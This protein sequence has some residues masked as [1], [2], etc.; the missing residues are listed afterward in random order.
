[1]QGKLPPQGNVNNR[2]IAKAGDP[3]Q[4]PLKEIKGEKIPAGGN[5]LPPETGIGAKSADLGAGP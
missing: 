5:I 3:V 2:V 1:M 4:E